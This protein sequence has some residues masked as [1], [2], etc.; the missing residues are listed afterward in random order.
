MLLVNSF[1]PIVRAN[2]SNNRSA[3]T[4]NS[5]Q[6]MLQSKPDM[7]SFKSDPAEISSKVKN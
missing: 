4:S 6:I 5:R 2:N 1:N 7:V 3:N